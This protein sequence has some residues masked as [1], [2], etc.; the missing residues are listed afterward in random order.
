MI[1]LSGHERPG[2]PVTVKL[3]SNGF[4]ETK[5]FHPLKP[6]SV[7]ANKRNLSEVSITLGS[8]RAK[9]YVITLSGQGHRLSVFI[10]DITPKPRI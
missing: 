9:F 10:V 2:A 3:C 4:E 5:H 8:A 6:Q 1:P 7:I